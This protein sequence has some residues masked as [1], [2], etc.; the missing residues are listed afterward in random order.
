MASVISSCSS[1]EDKVLV[2][3]ATF[4]GFA[5]QLIDDLREYNQ[6]VIKEGEFNYVVLYGLETTQK[7]IDRNIRLSLNVLDTLE[8]QTENLR[9]IIFFIERFCLL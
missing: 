7:L 1:R 5:F 3:Y 9:E 4:L 6:G 2:D 8:R